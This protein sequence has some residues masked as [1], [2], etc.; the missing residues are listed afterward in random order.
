[1]RSSVR[2]MLSAIDSDQYGTEKFSVPSAQRLEFGRA[3]CTV[4]KTDSTS[5]WN[6]LDERR[7]RAMDSSAYQ[8]KLAT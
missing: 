7:E 6:R 1:M 2:R 8:R 4:V 5:A 3:A